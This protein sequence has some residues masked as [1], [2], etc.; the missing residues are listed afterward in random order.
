MTCAGDSLKPI[1]DVD[2]GPAAEMHE[3]GTVQSVDRALELLEIVVAADRDL[4]LREISEA[5]GLP[6]ATTHRLLGVLLAHGYLAQNTITRRYGVGPAAVDLAARV[7]RGDRHALQAG[8]Y[9]RQLMELTDET[10]NWAVLDGDAIVYRA[11]APARRLVRMFTEPGNRA[12]LHASG[13]GKVLLA[14]L[15]EDERDALLARLELR[16]YTSA[17]MTD[18]DRFRR[19]LSTVREQGYALDEGEFED[20]VG[21][22]AVPVHAASGVVAGAMSISGPSSRLTPEKIKELA[23]KVIA[24]GRDFSRA[25][26]AS[27]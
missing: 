16:R 15:P 27:E 5:S 14:H 3:R 26:G 21:C 7:S 9:L 22:I 12:P 6:V 11:Q 19:H 24:V 17:T 13:I 18:R 4:G 25:L 10:A 2:H 1:I 20:G 8:P 23:P